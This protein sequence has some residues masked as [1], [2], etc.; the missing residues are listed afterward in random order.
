MATSP[1][2]PNQV[3]PAKKPK[4]NLKIAIDTEK[5]NGVGKSLAS[6]EFLGLDG[7]QPVSA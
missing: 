6:Q 3:I 4:L 5:L 2:T 7:T 1:T